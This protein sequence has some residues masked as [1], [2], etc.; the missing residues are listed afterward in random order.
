MEQAAKGNGLHVNADK[1]EFMFFSKDGAIYS[2]N[3]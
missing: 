3:G 2:L 1:A